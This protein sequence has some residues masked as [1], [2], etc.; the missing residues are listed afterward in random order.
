MGRPLSRVARAWV[1]V[2]VVLVLAHLAAQLTGAATTARVTQGL[3]MPALAAVVL[4][5]TRWPRGRRVAW[6]LVALGFSWLGDVLPSAV[7][8]D[9]AF[10]VMVG[11]FLLAQGAYVVAFAPSVRRS[12]VHRRPV[13]LVP[14][15]L[16]LV[17]LV[18]VCTP[19][20][21]TLLAPVAVYAG[22][23]VAMAVLA[24][25]LGRTGAVGGALFLVS[26]ALIAVDAFVPSWHLAGQGFWVM[27][28]Y[29]AGQALLAA[30]VVASNASE[31]RAPDPTPFYAP[32][33]QR[34]VPDNA[35]ALV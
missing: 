3:L 27:L 31:R 10:L 8:D 33:Q 30:A 1:A 28:T 4:T 23:L 9:A 34:A 22:V 19:G 25:G 13:L 21:G 20:A 11:C 14:Y 24:T 32:L 26:D 7:G 2:L 18:A 12:V 35:V 16:V 15:A 5:A 17:T 29:A 6:T